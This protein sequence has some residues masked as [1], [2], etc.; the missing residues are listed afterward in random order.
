MRRV[1]VAVVDE[2]HVVPVRDR[3]VPAALTMGMFVLRV[4]PVLY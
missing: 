3:N 2:V 1:A 4:R